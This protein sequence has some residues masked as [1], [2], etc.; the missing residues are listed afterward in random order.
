MSNIELWSVSKFSYK[1]ENIMN[2]PLPTAS[3]NVF[4]YYKSVTIAENCSLSY[5]N[6]IPTW[7]N[8]EL[9]SVS[10][11]TYKT[12]IIMKKKSKSATLAEICS[13]SYLPIFQHVEHRIKVCI[14]DSI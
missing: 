2:K 1:T 12:E 7:V 5:L 4:I 14:H 10:T 9:W 13:L 11:F 8:I 3:I 6:A